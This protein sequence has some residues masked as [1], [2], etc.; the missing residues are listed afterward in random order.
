MVSD[1][2][3]DGY[4]CYMT[5]HQKSFMKDGSTS[6]AAPYDHSNRSVLSSIDGTK[7]P[8]WRSQIANGQN[9]TTI[10]NGTKMKNLKRDH[11]SYVLTTRHPNPQLVPSGLIRYEEQ[12][13]G[14]PNFPPPLSPTPPDTSVQTRVTNRCIRKFLDQAKAAMSSVEA[15]QDFGELKQT[16]ESIIHPMNSLKKLTVGYFA[17]LKKAKRLYRRNR[18][19]LHKALADSYLEYRFGWRPL[20]MDIG[21]AI[22]GLQT[23]HSRFPQVPITASASERYN[24]FNSVISTSNPNTVTVSGNSKSYSNYQV[25]YKGAVRTGSVNGTIPIPQVLQIKTLNDFVVTAWDLVPYSWIV[26]YF[27]NIGDL[28][29]S[30][31]FLYSNIAWG[32]KTVR[33]VSSVE[34]GGCNVPSSRAPSGW[35]VEIE[36]SSG[37]N[38]KCEVVKFSRSP[39]LSADLLPRVEFHIPLSSR[40]WENIGALLASRSRSLVPL[41]RDTW[42]SRHVYTE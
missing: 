31:S 36:R 32:C 30:Y 8:F 33:M 29:N 15:G 16:L 12:C 24:G 13:S 10:R 26:D 17:K 22:V 5:N 11:F 6:F 3:F 2:A 41:F 37:G 4:E 9:A 38:Y 7:N 42:Q 39:L 40:P 14:Y 27:T 20:A 23:R 1:S 21:D 34:I 18:I 25:R 19:S 35:I 28:I